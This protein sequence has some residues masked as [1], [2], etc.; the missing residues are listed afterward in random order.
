MTGLT[1]RR[2]RKSPGVQVPVI[3]T[4]GRTVPVI[5]AT[6]RTVPVILTTGRTVP[7]SL[8]SSFEA[9]ANAP[10]L[11]NVGQLEKHPIHQI[12]EKR[13]NSTL[14][15]LIVPLY[16]N[17]TMV[18]LLVRKVLRAFGPFNS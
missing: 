2:R 11:K 7:I 4:I 8:I 13:D 5:L 14:K 17:L 9:L 16:Q 10:L 15:K 1:R 18:H 3:L 12:E 6:G